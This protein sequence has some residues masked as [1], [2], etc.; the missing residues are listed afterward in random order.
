MTR[1]RLTTALIIATTIL[2]STGLLAFGVFLYIG[3]LG[4]VEFGWGPGADL[5]WDACLSVLFFVQHSGMLRQRFRQWMA[6]FIPE[7]FLSAVYGVCSGGLL[8][9]LVVFWQSSPQVMVTLSGWAYLLARACFWLAVLGFIWTTGSLNDFD[10]IGMKP[11]MAG[12]DDPEPAP[13]S[14]IVN[15]PYRWVRHPF[16]FFAIVM[17][18]ACPVLTHDRLLFNLLW[19]LWIW[20]GARLEERDLVAVYGDAYQ[21]Y[22]LSVPMLLPFIRPG[23][24]PL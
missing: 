10:P 14:L 24:R 16:Y 3:P 12:P 11:L 22:Q 20:V 8:L 1:S 19:T 7:T 15:G 18:W 23:R 4:W 9:C 21:A 13:M 17:I 2:S 5:W 6:A